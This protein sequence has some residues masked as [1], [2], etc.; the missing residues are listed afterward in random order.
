LKRRSELGQLQREVAG[1][2]SVNIWTYLLWEQDRT[3]PTIRYYPAIFQ[4]L[5]YDPYP[6]PSTLAERIAAKRRELGLP[7][8][9]AAKL[10]GVDEGTFSRWETNRWT[11]RMSAV[12]A[13]RFLALS[14]VSCP[15][16]D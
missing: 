16:P 12:A 6:A 7:I 15:P 5:G 14:P 13:N 9:Q 3:T 1:R 4:F 8:K 2:L 10:A 11:G